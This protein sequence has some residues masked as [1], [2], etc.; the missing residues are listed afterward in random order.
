MAELPSYKNLEGKRVWFSNGRSPSFIIS[1]KSELDRWFN[2]LQEDEDKQSTKDATAL[3]YRGVTEAKY[4][5]YTSAQRLWVINEMQQW[6]GMTYLAFISMLIDKANARPVIREVFDLYGYSRNEREFPILSLLQH[7]G[8]PTPLL[9]W[10]YDVNVAFYCSVEGVESG[11]G[12]GDGIENYF[13]LYKLNKRNYQNEL[14]N[15]V[16]V[17]G[18]NLYPR[19]VDFSSIEERDDKRN[20]NSVF[21]L[22]DFEMSGE[23]RFGGRGDNVL[24]IRNHKPYTSV[25]NQNIISQK[26]MFIFNPISRIPLEV[27]FNVPGLA[28]GQNLK[29]TPFECFNIHKDLAEYLRRR[30]AKRRDVDRSFIYP[31]MVD[32]AVKA[33]NDALNSLV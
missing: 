3:I 33:K 14:L 23:S 2:M 13:S 19:I 15:I 28:E 32:E 6:A 30:L 10:S 17:K 16:D 22:S 18:G 11:T 12:N 8:A 29:L 1:T 20:S 7:Y 4:M 21:Y 26:G 9:D 24:R 25:Y 5:M 27:I 31:S